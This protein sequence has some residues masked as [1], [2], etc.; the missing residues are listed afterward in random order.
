MY[1]N[2]MKKPLI[3][4]FFLVLSLLILGCSKPSEPDTALGDKANL[5]NQSQ[6]DWVSS[7]LLYNSDAEKKSLS[8]LY[9]TDDA[10]SDGV[11]MEQNTFL[12]S[13]VII[14]L[15]SAYNV[16]RISTANDSLIQFQDRMITGNQ[17]FKTYNLVGVPS[18]LILDAEN[19]YF[20][21]IQ[22]NYYPS[23]SFLVLLQL[24]KEKNQ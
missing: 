24:Y 21:R 8:I 20:G 5:L 15:N 14:A 9:F 16:V 18:M 7:S 22:A 11:L 19:K 12:D 17:F 13:T 4:T 3:P 6:I 23:D 10:C 2:Y 1:T